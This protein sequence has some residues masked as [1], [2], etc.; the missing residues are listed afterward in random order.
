MTATESQRSERCGARE[1]PRQTWSFASDA[2]FVCYRRGRPNC[3]DM[4]EVADSSPR[5]PTLKSV[6]GTR[7]FRSFPFSCGCPGFASHASSISGCFPVASPIGPRQPTTAFSKTR[8]DGATKRP[9]QMRSF[10]R[11]GTGISKHNQSNSPSKPVVESSN[12]SAPSL[13]ISRC[14]AEFQLGRRLCVFPMLAA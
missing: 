7:G 14:S 11:A 12:P 5:G 4:D 6:N 9:Q 13:S 1:T 10:L 8:E 3:I 2:A